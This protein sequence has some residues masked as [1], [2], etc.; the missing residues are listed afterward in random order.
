MS[1]RHSGFRTGLS[2]LLGLS[3]LCLPAAARELVDA[4][5]Q[6]ALAARVN[7]A[8]DSYKILDAYPDKTFRGERP[9][10]RYELAD[11]LWRSLQYIQLRYGVKMDYDA[12][13]AAYY[14]AYLRPEGDI[15]EQHW[16][17]AALERVLGYGLMSGTPEMRFYGSQKVSRYMLALTLVRALDWLQIEPVQMQEQ[18][19]QDLPKDHWAA[20]AVQKLLNAKVLE[21][22]SRFDGEA[23]VSRYE[24]AESLVKLLQQV[25]LVAQKRPLVIKPLDVPELPPEMQERIRFD[26]RKNPVYN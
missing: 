14:Q 11:A 23:I 25:D 17:R 9:F 20:D 24:L 12:R 2:L 13:L 16:A 26:G 10:T 7:L 3:V 15:P 6:P 18:Q 1:W 19:L 21:A 22:G 4:P 5:Q 8:L